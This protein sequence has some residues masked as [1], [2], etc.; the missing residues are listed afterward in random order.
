MPAV[1]LVYFSGL[2]GAGLSHALR[3][4][5]RGQHRRSSF[6]D[7]LAFTLLLATGHLV[8][9]LAQEDRATET[10]T[11]I[12]FLAGISVG[13]AAALQASNRRSTD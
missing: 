5:S 2:A 4:I 10:L 9:R 6:W 8:I 1:L 3:V 12:T 13:L 7:T 11:S